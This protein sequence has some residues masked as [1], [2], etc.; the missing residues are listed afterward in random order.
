MTWISITWKVFRT[1]WLGA[2]FLTL[3]MRLLT[4]DGKPEGDLALGSIMLILSFP[5]GVVPALAGSWATREFHV[6]PLPSV[7]ETISLWAIFF[8]AGAFQWF[9]LP[10]IARKLLERAGRE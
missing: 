6:S 5:S 8:L 9:L 3:G 7:G 4:F 10:Y 1:A 2:C